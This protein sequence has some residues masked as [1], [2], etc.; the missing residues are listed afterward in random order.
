[1]DDKIFRQLDRIE[2]KLDQHIDRI[3]ATEESMR[4]VKGSIKLSITVLIAA[5]G[6]LVN[7]TTKIMN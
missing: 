7:I 1:M 5:V 3:S 2:R 4:W 6:W